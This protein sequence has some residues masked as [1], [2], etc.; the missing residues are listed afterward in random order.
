M[1]NKRINDRFFSSS[2]ENYGVIVADRVVSSH[3][4]YFLIA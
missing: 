3:F 2:K 4:D 1:L